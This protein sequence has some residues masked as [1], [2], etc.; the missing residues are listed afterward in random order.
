MEP[1][2]S[3]CYLF[4]TFLLLKNYEGLG[5]NSENDVEVKYSLWSALVYCMVINAAALLVQWSN[6]SLTGCQRGTRPK[7]GPL[8][9]ARSVFGGAGDLS[10]VALHANTLPELA[11]QAGSSSGDRYRGAVGPEGMVW[12]DRSALRAVCSRI[13]RWDATSEF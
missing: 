1:I 7:S 4:A 12:L 3:S 2:P 5:T 10:V 9:T 13:R 8:I 11:A 6:K